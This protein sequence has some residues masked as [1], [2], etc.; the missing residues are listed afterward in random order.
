MSHHW[1]EVHMCK[2]WGLEITEW[3]VIGNIATGVYALATLIAVLVTS[4][5]GYYAMKAYELNKK[6]QKID[7]GNKFVEMFNSVFDTNQFVGDPRE[8]F[9]TYREMLHTWMNPFEE[10]E[11]KKYDY[12]GAT[13][14]HIAP[15]VVFAAEMFNMFCMYISDGTADPTI[16]YFPLGQYMDFLYYRFCKLPDG[17]DKLTTKYPYFNKL[18]H[19][20]DKFKN[21]QF[22][23]HT[24]CPDLSALKSLKI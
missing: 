11:F 14:F 9:R 5:A 24:Y 21:L 15:E 6:Q 16:I 22:Q 17:Q 12:I 1:N 7:I 10:A 8:S 23:F 2:I 19:K 13:A 18:M 4:F 20:K 3:Q